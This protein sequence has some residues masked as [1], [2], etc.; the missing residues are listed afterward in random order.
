M[1][2]EP[3]PFA[4]Y[5]RCRRLGAL[6]GV[7]YNEAQELVAD[8]LGYRWRIVEHMVHELAHAAC[9][10]ID[11]A[12]VVECQVIS[13]AHAPDSFRV[14]YTTLSTRIGAML[15]GRSDEQ[16]HELRTLAI[17]YSVLRTLGLDDATADDVL[18]K[19]MSAQGVAYCEFTPRQ[20]R[21]H[22]KP[23]PSAIA[24]L[25][26]VAARRRSRELTAQIVTAVSEPDVEAQCRQ[27][28]QLAWSAAGQTRRSVAQ[29]DARRTR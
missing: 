16:R 11:L 6:L 25:R 2:I 21:D 28:A 9:L 26:A 29:R 14:E 13:E 20:L 10:R 3:P 4:A 7:D 1:V 17:E 27:V 24:V 18:A 19:I 12:D 15:S 8:I 5:A 22:R 23:L